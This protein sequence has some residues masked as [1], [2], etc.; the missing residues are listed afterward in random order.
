MALRIRAAA[1]R[2]VAFQLIPASLLLVFSL[3]G[4]LA[5]KDIHLVYAVFSAVALALAILWL[6]AVLYLDRRRARGR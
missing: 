5:F 3:A 4:V 1:D 2:P 6:S